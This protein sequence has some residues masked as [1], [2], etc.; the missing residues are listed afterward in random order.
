MRA[1]WA[2]VK[3]KNRLASVLVVWMIVASS[4]V[5]LLPLSTPKAKAQ[6]YIHDMGQAMLEDGGPTDADGMVNQIVVWDN[7]DSHIVQTHNY[8]VNPGY[9]LVIQ[10]LTPPNDVTFASGATRIDVAVDAKLITHDN[11]DDFSRTVFAA[12]GIGGWDGIYFLPGSEGR[13]YD[14]EF[15][16][17]NDGVVFQSAS[18]MAPGVSLSMFTN[19]GA[20]GIQMDRVVN[21]TNM[22]F[23]VIDDSAAP[24]GVCLDVRNGTLNL[25]A[26][27]SFIGHGIG[28][29]SMY[30]S[31]ANVILDRIN[32]NSFDIPGHGLLVEEKSNGTVLDTCEF[33]GGVPGNYYVRTNG[34]SIFMDN[35]SFYQAGASAGALTLKANDYTQGFPAHP[36]LRNPMKFSGE[37]DN[38]T[39]NSTGGSSVTL[40]W[41]IDVEVKDKNHTHIPYVPV[42]VKDRFGDPGSPPTRI[43][44]I[45]GWAR[46]FLVTEMIKYQ[47]TTKDFNPHNISA[48]NGTLWGYADFENSTITKSRDVLVIV[49]SNYTSP[50]LPPNMAPRPPTGFQA[51]LTFDGVD[52]LLSW[53]A[54]HDDG[55]GEDDVAGYT[56]YKSNTGI[57]GSY[58]YAA[59][60]P[61]NG[62]SSYSWTDIDAGDGDLNDYFYIVRAN[63]TSDKEELNTN[64]AG[65]F[66]NSLMDDCNLISIPLIQ[67]NTSMEHVLQT[68]NG[69]YFGVQAYHAGRSKPWLHWY[70]GKPIYFNDV[71]EINHKNGY[72]VLMIYR[73]YL[74]VAGK[75][76][77]VTQINLK[78]GW[79]LVGYPCLTNRTRDDALSSIAGNFN[80]VMYFDTE[81]KR[82]VK[83]GPGDFME[84]G[85]GYW[86]YATADCV[87]EISN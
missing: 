50:P 54:S 10:G 39:I 84:P 60:V 86:I 67:T 33:Q 70:K 4:I 64:K 80:M 12:S 2:N 68:I 56:V 59:W 73:D 8:L 45:N 76:P 46:W 58:D 87:W 74:I 29:P 7:S 3:D 53:D 61:A 71:I 82:E 48:Q 40:Q 65:K 38:T 52:V 5:L 32:F 44:D 63:D 31:N 25:T 42:Y 35:C 55:G 77:T 13:I 75:V 72:Y 24:T 49:P 28:M 81:E 78:I 37:W 79:N 27:V 17:A 1:E 16:G 21:Y 43:T 6:P 22:D 15:D 34:A 51:D 62:S 9:T 66:V 14:C 36:I 57:N 85:F 19:I 20:Y 41:W 26:G 18:L 47:H 69:S 11:E 30:V 83:L 23:T